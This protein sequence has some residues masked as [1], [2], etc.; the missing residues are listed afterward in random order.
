M[1][2]CERSTGKA[3]GALFLLWVFC[4][5]HARTLQAPQHRV[6]HFFFF[7]HAAICTAILVPGEH[8]YSVSLAR[9]AAT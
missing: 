9:V 3:R 7:I 4:Y 8:R 6:K 2:G 1:V 5:T